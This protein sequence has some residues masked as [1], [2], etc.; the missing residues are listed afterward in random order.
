MDE[1]TFL[2]L[3][4]SWLPVAFL[5]L[6]YL[7]GLEEKAQKYSNYVIAYLIGVNMVMVLI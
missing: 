2:I 3:L 6:G 7:Y 1:K 4:I 5:A